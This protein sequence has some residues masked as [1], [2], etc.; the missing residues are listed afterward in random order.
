MSGPL[1]RAALAVA[2]GLL[3]L[4][5]PLASPDTSAALG[6][7][8]STSPGD[9]AE[10]LVRAAGTDA[11]IVYA[12]SVPPSAAVSALL[13]GEARRAFDSSESGSASDLPHVVLS[14]PGTPPRIQLTAPTDLIA[15]RRAALDLVVRGT[16]S[17][18]GVIVLTE[19]SGLEDTVRVTFDESGAARA[20]IGVE[21]HRA[22]AAMWTARFEG[23]AA[24]VTGWVRP[25]ATVRALILTGPPGNESRQLV[26]ALESAGVDVVVRQD[27][28]RALTVASAGARMPGDL[29]ELEPFDVVAIVDPLA[30]PIELLLT[31]VAERGGGLLRVAAPSVEAESISG[32][33][34][35]GPAEV[36]PLPAAELQ[37]RAE[38]V[39]APHGGVGFPVARGGSSDDGAVHARADWLGR[40]R[41]YTSGL[42]SWPW[43]MEVGAVAA[44]RRHWESIVEWLAG[45]LVAEATLVAA[46]AVVGLAWSGRIDG[47]A[48]ASLALRRP[49]TDQPA[50]L[51]DRELLPSPTLLALPVSAGAH[52][53]SDA[54]DSASTPLFGFVAGPADVSSGWADA[55][56]RVGGAGGTVTV[57]DGTRASSR[58][59]GDRRDLRWLLFLM[60]GA[61]AGAGWTTRRIAGL[62]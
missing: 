41:V 46:P 8:S 9:L 60:V 27:L 45:G 42:Q 18:A 48:P 6:V 56:L 21:P 39:I 10:A 35:T 1:L 38:R 23:T 17:T 20:S 2:L 24:T 51:D 61:L 31:W 36:L 19:G 14:V 34:W 49:E 3:W 29:T 54:D 55:A 7:D 30:A 22:G 62:P 40:G 32:I 12:D 26:R 58:P 52:T 53:L 50:I 47:S 11:R 44:H 43:V 28:G 25:A 15:E 37:T 5:G 57:A 59:V 33:E 16:P 4:A 13:A